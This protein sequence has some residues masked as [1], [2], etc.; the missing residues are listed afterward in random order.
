MQPQIFKT[1]IALQETILPRL[2]DLLEKEVK[3]PLDAT[4][5]FFDL[6]E[7][8]NKGTA[9]GVEIASR[10]AR[11]FQ[12]TLTVLDT[13]LEWGV[14]QQLDRQRKWVG[15]DTNL[16]VRGLFARFKECSC[17]R[18]FSLIDRHRSDEARALPGAEIRFVL[19]MILYWLCE[20]ADE[21]E[22]AMER[23]DV[24]GGKLH[25]GLRLRSES[26]FSRMGRRVERV[27][28]GKVSSEGKSCPTE[29]FYLALARDVVEE[30]D[31]ELWVKMNASVIEAGFELNL[32]MR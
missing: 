10:A 5:S 4:V 21:G 12:Q 22:I 20:V 23:L 3:A 8:D 6:V 16:L 15:T 17:A 26:L 25:A 29:G 18:R 1:T 30:F 7:D 31:G 24:D 27:V 28:N 2:L 9:F 14:V 13:L 32:G 19:E 11:Q